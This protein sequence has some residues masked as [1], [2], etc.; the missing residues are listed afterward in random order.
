MQAS[1]LLLREERALDPP[2]SE[3]VAELPATPGGEA[4]ITR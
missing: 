2:K 4:S 3:R 1:L